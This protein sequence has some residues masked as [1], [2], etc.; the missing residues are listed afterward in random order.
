MVITVNKSYANYKLLEENY[1]SG[2]KVVEL[3]KEAYRLQQLSYE[4]GM[5]TF[6]DVQKASDDLQQA[7]ASLSECIYYYNTAKS[8]FKYNIYNTN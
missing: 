5:T 6:E 7:E 8:S 4:V 1:Q 3:R 2:L